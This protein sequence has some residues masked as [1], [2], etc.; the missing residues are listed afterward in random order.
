R[1]RQ[2]GE[3]VVVTELALDEPETLRELL[4]DPLVERGAGVRA[5]RVV[6]Y[7]TEV[8]V[9][10]LPPGEAGQPEPGWQQP[11][12]G[13]V[14]DSRQQLLPGQ[15]AGHPEQHQT[16]RSGDAGQSAVGRIAQRVV[17]CSRRHAG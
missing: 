10:P 14:V 12:V 16:T 3:G 13:Q 8:L 1:L 4:P 7:L 15:V 2:A 5:D 11:P 17:S 6:G 9:V